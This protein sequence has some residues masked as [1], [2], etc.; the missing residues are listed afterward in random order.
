MFDVFRL[1]EV[2]VT[3]KENFVSNGNYDVFELNE[4]LFAFDQPLI[5]A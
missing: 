4:V 5:G 3:Y 1:K 2:L